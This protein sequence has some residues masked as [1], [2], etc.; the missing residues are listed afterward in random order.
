MERSSPDQLRAAREALDAWRASRPRG[1]RIPKELWAHAVELAR[2]YGF[3]TTKYHLRLNPEQ[4]RRRL[5]GAGPAEAT[6][7]RDVV[8]QA[9]FVEVAAADLV[10]ALRSRLGRGTDA[11]RP[12][13]VISA[14]VAR[15]DGARLSL[16]LPADAAHL[17]PLLAAFLRG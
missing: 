1:A 5:D 13:D 3:A 12:A 15:A 9:P 11:P 10:S 4:F 7:S 17:G 8:R 16:D 2:T 14:R 6:S